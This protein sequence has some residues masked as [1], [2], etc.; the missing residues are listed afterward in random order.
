LNTSNGQAKRNVRRCDPESNSVLWKGATLMRRSFHRSAI[1][2]LLIMVLS[3]HPAAW[4]WGLRGTRLLLAQRGSCWINRRRTRCG[5]AA[6]SADATKQTQRPVDHSRGSLNGRRTW[7]PTVPEDQRRMFL[8]M[9][10][11]TWAT[12]S[13]TASHDSDVVPSDL[14]RQPQTSG[15]ADTESHGYCTL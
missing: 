6:A 3:I 12:A 11:A 15:L 10:A 7:R 14:M 2:C 9:R 5:P 4:S 1:A 13:S 8:F